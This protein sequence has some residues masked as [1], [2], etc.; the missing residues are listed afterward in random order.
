MSCAA[1]LIMN[2][3]T[4]QEINMLQQIQEDKVIDKPI[5][6]TENILNVVL[7]CEQD[8]NLRVCIMNNEF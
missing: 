1:L 6:N 4:I 3:Q 7:A 8:L 2:R 5:D